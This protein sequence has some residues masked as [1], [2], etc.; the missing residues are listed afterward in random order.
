M[1]II[2]GFCRN[3][4]VY[5][6]RA[7]AAWMDRGLNCGR[8]E[9]FRIRPDR[10]WGSPRILFNGNRVSSPGVKRPGRDVNHPPHLASRLR[11][12]KAVPLLPVW[13]FTTSS[14]TKFIFTVVVYAGFK[15]V[16]GKTAL[17]RLTLNGRIILKIV[18][19]VRRYNDWTWPAQDREK[20]RAVA[21]T[22]RHI[23]VPEQW[24]ISWVVK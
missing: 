11:K 20:W 5:E 13:A 2:L 22:V 16:E 19:I 12:S 3:R 7:Y 15:P 17:A 18:K 4:S 6:D 21:N 23:R 9:I 14:R 24:K 8:G 10:A 1:I